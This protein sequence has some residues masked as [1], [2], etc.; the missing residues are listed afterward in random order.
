MRA[1][2][3][4]LI[5]LLAAVLV[6]P[7]ALTQEKGGEGISGPYEAVPNWPQPLPGDYTGWTWGSVGGVYAE[8]ANRIWVAM[9]GVLP[10]PRDVKP[11]TPWG[12][13]GLTT[14][15]GD[16]TLER[17]WERRYDHCIFVVDRDGKQV[18]AWTQHDK[19]FDKPGARGPHKVKMS[20]YDA[21]K[22]VWVIDDNMHQIFK[23]TY[24]GQLVM[25]LGVSGVP[26]RDGNHFMR[27]TDI[28][29]LPDGTFFISDGYVGKR[30]AKF[31]KDGKFLMDWG[32]EGTGPGQFNT[33]HSVAIAKD[34]RVFVS[35]RSN[36]RIQVFDENGK[37]IDQWPN[38]RSPYYVH[39]SKDQYLWVADGVTQ[40]IVKYDL[41]G[42]MLY[43]WGTAGG[44]LGYLNGEHQISVD[45]EGNLYS[46]S[47]FNGRVTKFRPKAGADPTH[48][49]GPELRY[50][51]T[52]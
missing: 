22:H 5:I 39:M 31:D 13:L 9:R 8:N 7:A 24:D 40:K 50:P 17:L 21:E 10:I 51:P 32:S 14:T 6:A 4:T 47:V 27:P 49:V 48:L 2:H 37:F 19:L 26:G 44:D 11:F 34:R 38:I 1:R 3:G 12:E 16:R 42:K 30:V 15:G 23:F 41:N 46:A 28:D 25:T 43:G 29:W 35:D 20:P 18:A 45:E 36:S 52:D 33:V